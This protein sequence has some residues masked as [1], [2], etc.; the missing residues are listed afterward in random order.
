MPIVRIVFSNNIVTNQTY[1]HTQYFTCISPYIIQSSRTLQ[2]VVGNSSVPKTQT[3][4]NILF[5]IST[6]SFAGESTANQV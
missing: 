2:F 1:K 5:I 6:L 4:M 3:K